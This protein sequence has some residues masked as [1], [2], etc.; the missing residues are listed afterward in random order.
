METE[1]RLV[2]VGLDTGTIDGDSTARIVDLDAVE[3]V[4]DGDD[5]A[6]DSRVI[7]LAT[8][9]GVPVAELWAAYQWRESIVR[10]GS[11]ADVERFL[12][13]DWRYVDSQVGVES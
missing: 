4:P 2:Y 1:R 8:D 11:M 12:E 7:D 10:A 13:N 5:Y 9:H 6:D 3:Y